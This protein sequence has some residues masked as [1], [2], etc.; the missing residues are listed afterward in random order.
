VSLSLSISPLSRQHT[1]TATK[2]PNHSLITQSKKIKP[3]NDSY[4]PASPSTSRVLL[5]L[6]FLLLSFAYF[7]AFVAFFS[8]R[9]DVTFVKSISYLEIRSVTNPSSRY[10]P[11]F[12]T[13]WGFCVTNYNRPACAWYSFKSILTATYT[14]NPPAPRTFAST[15]ATLTELDVL[16]SLPLPV[17]SLAFLLLFIALPILFVA[18]LLSAIGVIVHP[19]SA[20]SASAPRNR[21]AARGL[22]V[23][24]SALAALTAALYFLA[25]AFIIA[26]GV[27]LRNKIMT[28]FARNGINSSVTGGLPA[29]VAGAAAAATI[30]AVLA[31]IAAVVARREETRAATAAGDGGAAVYGYGYPASNP[32]PATAYGYDYGYATAGAPAAAAAYA[33]PVYPEK[34]D[35]SVSSEAGSAPPLPPP[36]DGAEL[37][38]ASGYASETLH[39][40]GGAGAPAYHETGGAQNPVYVPAAAAN[41]PPSGYLRA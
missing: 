22:A 17:N 38:A 12:L 31:G 24:A 4:M 28:A 30:A 27:V 32:A 11:A 34:V 16:A 40:Y 23:A 25:F 7:P 21:R 37:H 6:A 3:T 15:T 10:T 19:G 29:D 39:S 8:G 5:A 18:W 41:S 26:F 1:H 13:L 14:L 36:K 9:S 33:A 20:V 2:Q 35:F